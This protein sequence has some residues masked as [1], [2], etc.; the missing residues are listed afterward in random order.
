MPGTDVRQMWRCSECE[1]ERQWGN[2]YPVSLGDDGISG[3]LLGCDVC[4]RVTEHH[5]TRILAA[6]RRIRVVA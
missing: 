6:S 5:F 2:G 1:E 4:G 3:A